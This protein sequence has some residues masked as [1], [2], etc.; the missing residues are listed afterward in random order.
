[1]AE[2]LLMPIALL[3][4]WVLMLAE[5]FGQIARG[6]LRPDA[7]LT[8]AVRIGADSLLMVLVICVIT[9]SVI[10]LQIAVQFVQNGAQSYVGGFVSLA[11]VR[12]IAPIFTSLAVVARAGTAMAGEIAHMGVTDQVDALK[13]FRVSPS[14]YL[15]VPRLLASM[16][17]LPAL[18]VVG[19]AT[20]LMASMWVAQTVAH[21]HPHIFVDNMWLTLKPYDLFIPVIKAT[22]F[23]AL[24][25]VICYESGLRR[26]RAAR[27]VGSAATRAA[28]TSAIVIILADL[29]LTWLLLGQDKH[30]L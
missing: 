13:I 3:G 26:A 5:A 29:A 8:Q 15:L 9:G 20:A 2:K 25:A 19:G 17:A 21:L 10:S 14:R 22:V 27:D 24:M 23:G 16:L 11:I 12:E 28:V 18:T 1:M 30:A 4:E 6:Y 7:I